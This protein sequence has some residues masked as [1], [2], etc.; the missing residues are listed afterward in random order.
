MR[1]SITTTTYISRR[2]TVYSTGDIYF[3]Y[4]CWTGSREQRNIRCCLYSKRSI[5]VSCSFTKFYLKFLYANNTRWQCGI[6][7]GSTS[8]CF[9][10]LQVRILKG[11]WTSVSC[12]CGVLSG[13]VTGRSLVQR[14]PTEWDVSECDLGNW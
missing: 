6:R 9:L 4:L 2:N 3:S 12:E 14:S 13:K 7:R 11:T 5:T 10:G 8:A 1:V